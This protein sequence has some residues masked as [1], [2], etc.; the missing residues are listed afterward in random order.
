M[1]KRVIKMVAI[2]VVSV[3][4]GMLISAWNHK[5]IPDEYLNEMLRKSIYKDDIVA[6]SAILSHCSRESK[7]TLL[8]KDGRLYL[9]TAI[10]N[11][12]LDMLRL[13]IAHGADPYLRDFRG[14]TILHTAAEV[15]SDGKIV[16]YLLDIG[17][18]PG[19]KNDYGWTPIQKALSE[20]NDTTAEILNNAKRRG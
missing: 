11:K 13:L 6:A 15:D 19:A 9:L 5:P 18:D 4:A 16:K 1:S 17:L 12:D 2:V 7:D 3:L 20:G 8:E 10:F 14:N